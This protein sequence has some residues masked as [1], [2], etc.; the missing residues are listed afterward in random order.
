[1]T[2][3]EARTERDSIQ[4]DMLAA[5]I[6][7]GDRL[8]ALLDALLPPE[9]AAVDAPVSPVVPA[10]VPMP[11]ATLPRA[12][13]APTSVPSAADD[14]AAAVA[15]AVESAPVAPRAR[16]TG[17]RANPVTAAVTESKPPPAPDDWIL[18]EAAIAGAAI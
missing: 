14:I 12:S 9:D 3:T 8:A 2:P 7:R 13:G 1:M 6:R 5:A 11:T 15:A 17:K 16:P 4:A 10:A 18:D